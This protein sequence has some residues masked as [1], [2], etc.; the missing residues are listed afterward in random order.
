MCCSDLECRIVAIVVSVTVS[1]NRCEH[2]IISAINEF[3]LNSH[4]R[5][6]TE[7]W[8]D[9]RGQERERAERERKKER[10]MERGR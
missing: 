7:E 9:E 8:G 10:G 3:L 6:E 2:F 1:W 4:G 5:K